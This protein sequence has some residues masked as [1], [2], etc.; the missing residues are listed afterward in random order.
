MA[1]DMSGNSDM[2]GGRKDG[3]GWLAR[4]VEGVQARGKGNGRKKNGRGRLGWLAGCE[5]AA[6]V[7]LAVTK[8]WQKGSVNMESGRRRRE[9][10]QGERKE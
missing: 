4:V 1:S 3:H 10:V 6:G 5:V 8:R 7:L 9:W 2:Q